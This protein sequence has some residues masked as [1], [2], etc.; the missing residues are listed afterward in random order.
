M[1]KYLYILIIIVLF[2]SL[3]FI[4]NSVIWVKNKH[5]SN[6]NDKIIRIIIYINFAYISILLLFITYLYLYNYK[7]LLRNI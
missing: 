2:I 3:F 6:I 1:L 7:I 4:F 5:M